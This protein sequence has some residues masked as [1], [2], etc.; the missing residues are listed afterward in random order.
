MKITLPSQRTRIAFLMLAVGAL[1]ANAAKAQT[2]PSSIAAPVAGETASTGAG[3]VTP[4]PLGWDAMNSQDLA[5]MADFVIRTSEEHGLFLTA[6]E[7]RQIDQLR[8]MSPESARATLIPMFVSMARQLNGGRLTPTDV[9]ND[10]RFKRK[11]MKEDEL[12]KHVVAAQGSREKLNAAIAPQIIEYKMLVKMMA[13]LK[14]QKA[15]QVANPL[16]EI[17]AVKKPLKLGSVDA[18]IPAI[19]MRLAALGF[20][21]S[22]MDNKFDRETD[23][24]VADIQRQMKFKPD[25]VI[26]PK[27]S[28]LRYLSTSVDAR[29]QQVRADLEKLRWLPQDPGRKYIFVNLAF[30]S[31]IL[32]DYNQSNPVVMN[33][34]TINGRVDRKT[35][36]MADKIFQVILNPFWTVPPTVFI[37]DKV[38]AIKQLS[39]WEIDHYFAQNHYTVVSEN[40]RTQ[41]NPSSIDWHNISSSKVGFYIRQLPNYY[42][43][44]GVVK[45]SMTNGEAIYLHDTGERGLFVEENRL[46]SSGC[47]RVEQPM[48]LAEYL[49]KGT[50]WDRWAIE[51]HVARPGDVMSKDTPIDLKNASMNVYMLPVTSHL[52]SDQIMRFSD[53]VYGHNSSIRVLTSSGLY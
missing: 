21:M 43:A 36:S 16:P 49:L 25:R 12:Q 4:A 30:S 39:Y 23:M 18:S 14:Q 50:K 19:K 17:P 24:A 29:I 46:R 20:P 1:A 32:M 53:D 42:N 45:F 40:F 37:K 27:G 9:G 8:M 52:G 38:E 11:M 48:E 6:N 3:I 5:V 33:F 15:E 41:Y 2:A 28:T 35:P 51:N 26:S 22:S 34:R 13:R 10:I 44:L 47:V 31:L 7:Q